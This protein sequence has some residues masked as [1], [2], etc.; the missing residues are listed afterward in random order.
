MTI[1][2]PF[3][4]RKSLIIRAFLMP[5]ILIVF[6]LLTGCPQQVEE[7]EEMEE[8]PT[9]LLSSFPVC[10]E[11]ILPKHDLDQSEIDPVYLP[12]EVRLNGVSGRLCILL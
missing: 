4:C 8:K 11:M 9:L 1:T 7:E 3:Q 6:S 5:S 10:T 12:L 2:L